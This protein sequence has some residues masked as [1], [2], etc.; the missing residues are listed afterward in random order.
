MG[1]KGWELVSVSSNPLTGCHVLFWKR[2]QSRDGNKDHNG[3]HFVTN[4]PE[5]QYRISQTRKLQHEGTHSP[6]AKKS[7]QDIS[8]QIIKNFP[9]RK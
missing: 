7:N 2:P 9:S 8:G 3:E 6:T 1:G 5:E 4:F